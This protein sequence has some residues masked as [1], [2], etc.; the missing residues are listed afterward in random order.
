MPRADNADTCFLFRP[1][2]LT[3]A[4]KILRSIENSHDTY[5]LV[6]MNGEACAGRQVFKL[7]WYDREPEET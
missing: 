7:R 3:P 4:E 1:N 5:A 6:E 2:F